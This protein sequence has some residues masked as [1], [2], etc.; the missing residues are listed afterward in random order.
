MNCAIKFF[1][2]HF[3]K[4]ICNK[5]C[6]FDLIPIIKGII[7]ILRKQVLEH[8]LTHLPTHYV[9]RICVLIVSKNCHL[10]NPLTLD[11]FR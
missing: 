6:S 11:E 1:F 7:H 8:F 10:L 2:S 9:S 3:F 5:S 4:K